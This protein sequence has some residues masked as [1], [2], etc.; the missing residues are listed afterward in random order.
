VVDR[1]AAPAWTDTSPAKHSNCYAVAAL[2][3][4]S[5]NQSHHSAA[6][7]ADAGVEIAMSDRRVT[8]NLHL[9]AGAAHLKDW[10][11]PQDSL[12]VRQVALAAGRYSFQL[13][14][15]NTGHAINTGISNGV[16]V[17]SVRD[18]GGHMVAW[19]VIQMPHLP[20]DSAPQYS[21]P[22]D[23]L[24]GAG[25]YSIQLGDFYNMSYLA[26]N[27]VYGAGGGRSGPLNR[28]DIHALRIRT[29]E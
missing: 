19:R 23:V 3:A 7:C 9:Q 11:A 18:A 14:Y 12:V 13:R 4:D 27:S 25:T 1:L 16:K 15:K 20:A 5:G 21:T 29:L 6:V 17:L 26:S 10:G 22:A 8:S 2:A 28:A 24:L